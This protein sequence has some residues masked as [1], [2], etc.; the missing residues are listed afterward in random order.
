[1]QL[2]FACRVIF[3]N[4]DKIRKLII[5]SGAYERSISVRINSLHREGKSIREIQELTGPSVASIRGYLPSQKTVYKMEEITVLAERLR[6]YRNRK[7]AVK[8]LRDI[9]MTE[10]SEKIKDLLWDIPCIV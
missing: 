7:N 9:I 4:T 6:K 10:N 2:Q 3:Y 8:K 5:T 1:M